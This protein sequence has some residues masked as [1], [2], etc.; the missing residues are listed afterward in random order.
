MTYLLIRWHMTTT[1]KTCFKCQ[2]QKSL[3]AF[4]R[5]SMMKDGH[6]NKCIECTKKDVA[7][8]RAENLEKVRQY[9][10]DRSS[11]PHRAELRKRVGTE[12]L[13]LNS[14]KRR[15]QLT[16]QSAVKRK[17][18]SRPEYCS[19]CGD[20]G[21]IEAHH[22]DYSRPLMVEW[23]CVPCHRQAHALARKAA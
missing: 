7:E 23:L 10:R 19:F 2:L 12:W 21:M 14:V 3:D 8:H 18:M 13:R 20:A 5:H 1:V 11:L 16:V 17:E 9:D 4:Y 22:P 6:L 15:A